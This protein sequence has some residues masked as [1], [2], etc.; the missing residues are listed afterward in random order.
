MSWL[1]LTKKLGDEDKKELVDEEGK[2]IIV[3][4]RKTPGRKSLKVIKNSPM[5]P[6]AANFQKE[7]KAKMEKEISK[8]WDW[9][10]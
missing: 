8:A 1:G 2:T 9:N 5:A 10:D 6:I 4:K 3:Q 7:L